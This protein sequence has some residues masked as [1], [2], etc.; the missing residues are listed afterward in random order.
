LFVFFISWQL[1]IV[2]PSFIFGFWLAL[3]FLMQTSSKQNYLFMKNKCMVG[4]ITL[5]TLKYFLLQYQ[6][7]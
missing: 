6:L 2:C 3:R 7:V 4:K 5:T 1:Y